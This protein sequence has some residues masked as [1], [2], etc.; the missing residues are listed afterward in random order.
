MRTSRRLAKLNEHAQSVKEGTMTTNATAQ[1]FFDEVWSE[2]RLEL[3][4]ELFAPE[5]VGH[6]SGPEETVRGPE[7]V[8]GYVGRLR[9][10]VPDLT[11]TIEDQVIDDAKVATRWTARGTHD[12]ALLGIQPTGR[13]ATVTGITIQR[14]G[15]AGQIVEGWT[16]WDM[17]GMF[18]Q[19]GVAP[20]P[21]EQG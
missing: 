14:I 18:Q 10:G 4:D 1:R 3:V 6:P 11:V 15:D 17:L 20:L 13:S 21:G 19:L 7:G 2:G 8:K 9:A 12:G 16:N 5:Y